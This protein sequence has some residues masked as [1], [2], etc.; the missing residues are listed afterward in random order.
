MDARRKRLPVSILVAALVCVLSW[1]A[2]PALRVG[3]GLAARY[4]DNPTW[5][6]TPVYSGADPTPST[7]Q[8]RR[9]WGGTEPTA[10]SVV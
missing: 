9:R 1:V 2:R 4:Y 10:F 8:I 3:D 5:T 7:A 6:G